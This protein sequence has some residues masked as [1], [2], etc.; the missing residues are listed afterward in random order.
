MMLLAKAFALLYHQMQKSKRFC[1]H[2]LNSEPKLKETI[3]TISLKIM[4]TVLRMQAGDGGWGNECELTAYAVMTVSSLSQLPWTGTHGRFIDSISRGKTFLTTR[5]S[6]WKEGAPLWTEKVTYSSNILSQA[7]CLAAVLSHMP[8]PT[9]TNTIPQPFQVSE[10][11]ARGM[12]KALGLISHTP[13]FSEAEPQILRAA[14]LQ[15]CWAMCNLQRRRLHIFPRTG[16]GEDKYLIFIPLTWTACMSLHDDSVSLA[17]LYD[18]M[19]L[20]MLNYQVDEYMEVVVGGEAH[21]EEDF[22]SAREVVRQLFL[23]S[24]AS[25]SRDNN[26]P[27]AH[28]IPTMVPDLSP[29]SDNGSAPSNIKTVLR[30]YVS[31]ILRHPAVLN[32]PT[33]MQ[34]WLAR[35]LKIFL[36]AHIDHAE[37]NHRFAR[38]LTKSS[39]SRT[40]SHNGIKESNRA[41]QSDRTIITRLNGTQKSIGS[42]GEL[43]H[44]ENPGRTFYNWVHSTS[45][46]HTSCPFS[47]IYFNCLITSSHGDVLGRGARAAYL[48]EDV[49]R[50]L[51]SLCRM[52]NDYGSLVRD[53]DETN[54]NSVNF[55]E[56]CTAQRTEA[57]AKAELMSIAEY[58]RRGLETALDELERDL[59]RSGGSSIKWMDAIRLFVKVTDLYGQIY[60]VKDIA[61][62]LNSTA[63]RNE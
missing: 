29:S 48:A 26:S 52:Y 62:R 36:L 4:S 46:D 30:R 50:H 57:E 11:I 59:L 44:Y 16:M 18:M 42:N 49:C 17:V 35:E 45:A 25:C 19:V 2:L 14:E 41:N 7:Y 60:V 22:A 47:F 38:Q 33:F 32:S 15:A 55:P 20:S 23:E 40:P 53:R 24:S 9:T 1:E 6:E 39:A 21:C 13:L 31:H 54:L 3:P 5:R 8:S 12:R 58:E 10:K 61:T 27:E 56:F 34:V 51:A 37:D 63:P 43:P 28:C